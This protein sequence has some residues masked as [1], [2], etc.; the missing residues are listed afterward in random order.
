VQGF[1][2]RNLACLVIDEADRILEIGFEEEMKQVR[3]QG[4]QARTSKAD[5]KAARFNGTKCRP[6]LGKRQ[7]S[8]MRIAWNLV[9]LVVMCHFL[10]PCKQCIAST[11]AS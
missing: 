3:G 1:L 5:T 8:G 2:Y 10:G 4:G 6:Q 7:L 9:L 11:T